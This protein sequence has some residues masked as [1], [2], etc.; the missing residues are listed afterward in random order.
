MALTP[1]DVHNVA[2]S[3]ARIGKRG[4]SEQEVDLFIDLVEQELIRHI[5]ED[6]ELRSR[7]AELRNRDGGIQK[8]EA[9]L[10]EREASLREY[11]GRVRKREG[12]LRQREARL[13]QQESQ[14]ARQ[15]TPLPQQVAQLRHRE[16]QVAQREAQLA[17]HDA[18]L[19]QHEAQ[20]AQREAELR[21]Q[22][23]DLE[24][25]E[26]EFEQHANQVEQ[27]EAELGQH[28]AELRQYEAELRQHQAALRQR[29]DQQQ[30][31]AARINAEAGTN[32]VARR[33]PQQLRG[34]LTKAA[35]V[36]GSTRLEET[37]AVAAVRGRHDMERMAIRA[38]TDTHGN[39]VTE[40][41][42]ERTRRSAIENGGLSVA[43]EQTAL[44]EQ[45]KEEN[46]ELGRS[47]ALLKSA[48]AALA[49]ALDR[50]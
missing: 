11:E 30:A 48:A 21:Q 35:A 45:L 12:Q 25:Q 20:L 17:Q 22:E 23:V 37:H 38:V 4:Y 14:L 29:I 47:L 31:V 3:R 24:Q 15:S 28:E 32:Q 42:H 26:A 9:D 10:A 50:S 19:A 7:N 13:A 5:E 16:A 49:T 40:T 39:T 8:R 41:V 44:I 6:S 36:N 18:Q 1:A 33:H 2:F 34:A 46:A 27:R 43:S